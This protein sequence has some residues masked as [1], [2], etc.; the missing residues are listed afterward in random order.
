MKS[1][2]RGNDKKEVLENFSSA[3][4]E[5]ANKNK[6]KLPSEIEKPQEAAP[7]KAPVKDGN[8]T[9]EEWGEKIGAARDAADKAQAEKAAQAKEE[10]TK[11][12]TNR[13]KE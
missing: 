3:L 13:G 1:C 11:K 2:K 7:D 12:D 9:R 10:K 4:T 8:L 5:R 6:I